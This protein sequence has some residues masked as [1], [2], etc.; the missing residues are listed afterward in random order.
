M[1]P[2]ERVSWLFLYVCVLI[3]RPAMAAQSQ[4]SFPTTVPPPNEQMRLSKGL[5]LENCALC[6]IPRKKNVKSTNGD[7][8][9]IGPQL[10]GILTGPKAIPE[11]VVRTFIMNGVEGKM[12]SF[13]YGL[14]PKEIDAI[15]TYL[16]TL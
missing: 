7:G 9:S 4:Q 2:S 16:K 14:E 12:P 6:H 11:A 10:N 13:K 15:I 8:S 3:L 5:F 1:N